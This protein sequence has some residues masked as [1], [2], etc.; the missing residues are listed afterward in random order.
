[1]SKKKKLK[2]LKK[3]GVEITPFVHTGKINPNPKPI[4]I[5]SYQYDSLSM[6]LSHKGAGLLLPPGLGKTLTS[7]CAID[8]L[9]KHKVIDRVIIIAPLRVV[10]TVWRQEV[11]KW[12]FD[13]SV[14]ILH[15]SN[16]DT[17][18]RQKHDIYLINPEG[19]KWLH[20]KHIRFIDSF[21]FMLVV[22]E[23]TLFKNHSSQRF[24]L[25]KS[26]IAKFTRRVILTGTPVPN[27]LIQLWPQM[28]ILD[29][30][31][32]LK[33]NITSYRRKW[34]TKKQYGFGYDINDGASEE[35]YS[36]VSDIVIHKSNDE[37]NLPPLIKN[38]INVILPSFAKQ[39]YQTMRDSFMVDI[40]GIDEEISAVN[41]ASKAIKLKQIANGAIYD[42]DGAPVYI[43]DEK[44]N[45]V[46]EMVDSLGG[47]P[48]LIVYEYK[49]DLARLKERFKCPH[50]GG[51]IDGKQLANIIK[52][53][54]K[55]R[56]PV[57]LIQPR[58][59]G[60]G[61]NLQ[62]GGCHDVLNYSITFDLELYE[63]VYRRAYRQGVKNS[64]T[65]HHIIAEGTVDEH[66][67]KVLDGKANLQDE[68]LKSLM[69]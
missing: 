5:H 58:A 24:I 56:I 10:H 47:S 3:L 60:H 18:I 17:I 68:L 64:V 28:Y 62:D 48:L 8:T 65:V 32:R 46:S 7:L 19:V 20:D 42:D 44:I 33:H 23:S 9:I 4:T 15:G 61:L 22:D 2:K 1:M 14:G 54:N 69:R 40:E 6:I 59:G 52:D 25:L 38:N 63:Q 16:K 35:I 12:G 45:A 13:L 29:G 53:W 30:G 27:G 39:A 51:G 21:N 49:H 43:H 67:M 41:A 31:S 50:I 57:L 55:G 37:L 36:A 26:M 34:F 11:D 66:V